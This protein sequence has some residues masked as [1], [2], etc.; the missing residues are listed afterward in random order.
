MHVP[1]CPDRR[2]TDG[3]GKSGN[4]IGG[5]DGAAEGAD[6]GVAILHRGFRAATNTGPFT[7]GGGRQRTLRIVG[8]TGRGGISWSL[9]G[10]P[11][12]TATGGRSSRPLGGATNVTAGDRD[13][14]RKAPAATPSPTLAATTAPATRAASGTRRRIHQR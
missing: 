12:V 2:G 9:R 1:P 3:D 14:A 13:D 7:A 10:T 6:V 8:T 11:T 5:G 4:D